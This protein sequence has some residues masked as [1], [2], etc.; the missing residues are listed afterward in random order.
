MSRSKKTRTYPM[1]FMEMLEALHADPS[2]RFTVKC[3]DAKAAKSLMM[4]ISSFRSAGERE[5]LHLIYPEL[6]ALYVKTWKDK[7]GT[8]LGVE[9]MHR[10]FS[11]EALMVEKALAAAKLK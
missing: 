9:I 3:E 8:V 10:D 11:P 5:E 1:Q 7:T 6:S 2:Q 4:S